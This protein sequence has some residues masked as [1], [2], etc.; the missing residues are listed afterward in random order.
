M[1]GKIRLTIACGDYDIVR[2]LKDGP[3]TADGIELG[4]AGG[5]EEGI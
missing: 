5:S 3:V 1:A 2:A 4:D